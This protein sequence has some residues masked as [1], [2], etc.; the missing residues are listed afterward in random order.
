MKL[1][2]TILG[3]TLASAVA[4]ASANAADMYVPSPAGGYKD[5]P[6]AAPLWNGAYVG[7]NGGYAW[8]GDSSVYCDGTIFCDTNNISASSKSFASSGGFGGGQ[9]GYN[10][11]PAGAGGYKDGPAAGNFVFGIEADIQGADITGSG[12]LIGS[13]GKDSATATDSLNWFGTVRGRVG[14]AFGSAL[15]YGTGGVAFGGVQDKLTAGT[16]VQHDTTATGYAA[17]GGLEYA[18]NPAW[19]GKVEYQYINLGNDS[20]TN[21]AGT[22]TADF[23]HEY[24]TVRLGLNYH[25]L[26]GYEPLK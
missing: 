21:T 3:M 12:A 10:W 18:F 6:V 22:V 2:Y 25:I 17:G 8:G 5:G 7:I 4:I 1:V 26:P 23:N 14:Y 16:T 20:L 15:L 24:N 9:I 11:R 19:S 13:P